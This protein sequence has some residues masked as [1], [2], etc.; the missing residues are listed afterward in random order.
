VFVSLHQVEYALK[1]CPRTIALK[2][3]KIAYDG[4]SSALTPQFLNQLYG[5]ESE[6]LFLSPLENI[7]ASNG[8]GVGAPEPW[9]CRP[10]RRRASRSRPARSKPERLDA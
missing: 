3:G 5:A 7:G 10:A 9:A 1:Y 4:P 6:E 2:A 8:Q